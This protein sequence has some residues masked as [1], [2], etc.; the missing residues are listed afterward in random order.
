MSAQLRGRSVRALVAAVAAFFV[1]AT[2]PSTAAAGEG[3]VGS[4]NVRAV[5]TVGRGLA[6]GNAQLGATSLNTRVGLTGIGKLVPFAT[7]EMM[8]LALQEEGDR[9]NLTTHLGGVGAKYYLR[10]NGE[11][12]VNAY[13]LAEAFM[14]VPKF[15][16]SFS[17]DTKDLGKDLSNL[18][19]LGGFGA[20][21]MFSNSF[22]V[23]GEVGVERWTLKYE[24]K[25]YFLGG[26]ITN[27][28]SAMQLNFYF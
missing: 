22:S 12:K 15:K 26:A 16:D 1:L 13:L 14:L 7:Y 21:Y 28:F 4:G 20:E 5:L 8:S 9:V 19:G 6:I 3:P 11:G 17:G 25:G 10:A 18:G 27:T 23:S 24:D 2:A